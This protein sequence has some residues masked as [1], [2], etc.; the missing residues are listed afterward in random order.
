MVCFQ[1][2]AGF[3]RHGEIFR[4]G[5]AGS[6]ELEELIEGAV[7]KVVLVELVA[8]DEPGV[9]L[10]GARREGSR[11]GAARI[12][13][14]LR[15]DGSEEH[16]FESAGGAPAE[17]RGGHLID[18]R[19]F[20]GISRLEIAGKLAAEGFELGGL[21]VRHMLAGAEAMA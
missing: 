15:D 1:Q 10:A 5:A 21:G 19:R 9:G 11:E 8:P 18:E 16:G 20:E 4:D 13:G 6:A 3:V 17:A 14:I 7:I 12:S 2:V